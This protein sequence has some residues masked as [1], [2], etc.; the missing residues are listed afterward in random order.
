MVWLRGGMAVAADVLSIDP[1]GRALWVE[2]KNKGVPGYRYRRIGDTP[3]GWEHGVNLGL[4]A[5][6]YSRLAAR[7]PL[8][9]VVHEDQSPPSNDF[10]PPPPPALPDGRPDYA[11]YRRYLVASDRW[12]TIRFEDA[13]RFGREQRVWSSGPGWLWP[14]E[15]MK[16]FT[17]RTT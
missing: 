14:R 9:I 5:K 10:H 11:D 17:M 3:P 6:H 16:P 2:V 13:E 15:A 12:L 4:F 7:A 8:W 1:K